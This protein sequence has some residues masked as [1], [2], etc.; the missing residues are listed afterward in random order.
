MKI[1]SKLFFG[2]AVVVS[3]TL[4]LGI[5]TNSQSN[6]A[7]DDFKSIAERDLLVIQN[8]E[9]LQRL[10]VDSENGQRG[11]IITGNESFLEPYNRG[12]DE[13][14][15]L[16]EE[17]KNLVSYNPSQ[18]EK[19][20]HISQLF[21]D[22]I[23][24]AG[25]PEIELAR[26]I[27]S[28][29]D[30]ALESILSNES[31]IILDEIYQIILLLEGN[32]RDSENV[33][34]F[35]LL[36][37]IKADI[38]DT[39]V[40]QREYLISGNEDFLV[41]FNSVKIELR[42]N[43]Q[44]LENILKDDEENLQLIYSIGKLYQK[45]DQEVVYPNIES[46]RNIVENYNLNEASILLEKE[47]GKRILDEIRT[48][49]SEFIQIE[50]ENTQQRLENSLNNQEL[51]RNVIIIV[52]VA[53]VV[54]A[55]VLAFLILNS[56]LNPLSK[57]EKVI[58]QFKEGDYAQKID[59]NSNDELGDFSKSFDAIREILIKKEKLKNIGELATR[60]AHDLRNPLAVIQGAVNLM[61]T[62]LQEKDESLDKR[63]RMIDAAI[64]RMTHQIND[65]MDFVRVSNLQIETHSLLELLQ[66]SISRTT[67]NDSITIELPENDIKL[68]CD[69]HKL[70]I[71]FVNL[72]SN[73]IDAVKENGTIKIR[74]FDETSH[75]KIEL[76]DSGS[77]IPP[78]ILE[79][80]FE[81]LFTTKQVG[82]GLGLAS[83][84]NIVEQ[85]RGEI[86]AKTNP[87]VI[88]LT[89]SKTL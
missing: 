68:R 85:H 24:S 49:F 31:D 32:L 62:D 78:N 82:T 55:V 22:W 10:A 84:K 34:G 9:K 50:N 53:S 16:L 65:V 2:F 23:E 13:F 6:I 80:M 48:E 45:W 38:Y 36:G 51:V 26:Q 17:E 72:L 5:L 87:T 83:C 86:S 20:E 15:V 76:E 33:D 89:L 30:D 74:F 27:H 3:I 57:L 21:S 12:V 18:V 58:Q 79:E 47:T 37:K 59:I 39:E 56:V 77:P 81:P 1:K 7:S 8:A 35:L 88:S 60:L 41:S 29:Q 28:S 11:F 40:S 66:S 25:S 71:L 75:V 70:D 54:S 43:I 73:A 46:R 52:L 44:N 63:F 14:F 19:L 67:K 61:K 42:E 64:L 4:F 69:A